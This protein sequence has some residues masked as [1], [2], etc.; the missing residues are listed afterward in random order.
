MI[1]IATMCLRS[2]IYEILAPISENFMRSMSCDPEFTRLLQKFSKC[3][4]IFLM[5]N[6]CTKFEMTSFICY[7]HMAGPQ[8]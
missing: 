5:I 2:T 3:R 6:L 4:V 7:K 1:S 8:M